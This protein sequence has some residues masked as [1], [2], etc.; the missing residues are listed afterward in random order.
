[1]IT[2]LRPIPR[3]LPGEESDVVVSLVPP[4]NTPGKSFPHPLDPKTFWRQCTIYWEL[5]PTF[6][7]QTGPDALSRW[8]PNRAG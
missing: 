4:T 3:Y 2:G 7:C 6:F 8:F 1:M 5:I